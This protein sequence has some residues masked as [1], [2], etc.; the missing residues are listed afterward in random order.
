MVRVQAYCALYSLFPPLIIS[1]VLGAEDEP[2]TGQGVQQRQRR[3]WKEQM[4]LATSLVVVD[5]VGVGE[6]QRNDELT[7]PL[8]RESQMQH[9]L[10]P[11]SITLCLVSSHTMTSGSK[12]RPCLLSGPL[13]LTRARASWRRLL[14]SE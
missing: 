12:T 6:W 5:A 8:A 9:G 14:Q 2:C 4:A 7:K 11:L 1:I 13:T 10:C 3:G